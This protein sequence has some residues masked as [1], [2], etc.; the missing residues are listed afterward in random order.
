MEAGAA[1]ELELPRNNRAQR[2]AAKL[3]VPAIVKP[4]IRPPSGVRKPGQEVDLAKAWE[5][6]EKAGR[7]YFLTDWRGHDAEHLAS[8]DNFRKFV[9]SYAK[10]ERKAFRNPP[11]FEPYRMTEDEKAS[12]K[13]AY[14]EAKAGAIRAHG[15]PKAE[16]DAERR[17]DLMKRI[18]AAA[19][20][21]SGTL[22]ASIRRS[23]ANEAQRMYR[24]APEDYM[25]DP[26]AQGKAEDE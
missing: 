2:A 19:L 21:A 16:R 18:N 15:D 5:N 14:H 9:M 26:H 12:V 1:F 25:R 22:A 20:R 6:L 8:R 23:H 10:A 13:R 4:V 11:R 17:K 7:R 3:G 24:W